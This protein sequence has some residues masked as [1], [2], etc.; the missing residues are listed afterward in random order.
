MKDFLREEKNVALIAILENMKETGSIWN[1]EWN[2]TSLIAYNPLTD[3]NYSGFNRL[4]LSWLCR[5]R[6][7]QDNRFVTYK[8]AQDN[9]L[10]VP[11]GKKGYRVDYYNYVEKKDEDDK[12]IDSYYL[13]KYYTV[14]SI[15]DLE[16]DIS[17]IKDNRPT[18]PQVDEE[19]LKFIDMLEKSSLAKIEHSVTESIGFYPKENKIT[20][21]P[22]SH[23]N[24][25]N[26]YVTELLRLMAKATRDEV[27]KDAFYKDDIKFYTVSENIVCEFATLFT[28]AYFGIMNF[29]K[30][31]ERTA[32]LKQWLTVPENEEYLMKNLRKLVNF[33]EKT[34][35]FMR[36]QMNF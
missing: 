33:A 9:G 8:Q 6:N 28:E 12:V 16:G 15:T 20:I 23:F 31:P 25:A 11:E 18:P 35:I 27:R 2:T 5:E 24:S 10:Q 3:R 21:P 32:L 34:Q 26:G 22:L 36:K 13:Y 29:N 1:P 14:F 7:L 4:K 19:W 17:K 30:D